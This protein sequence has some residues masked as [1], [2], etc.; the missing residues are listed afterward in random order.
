MANQERGVLTK[1]TN[2]DGQPHRAA[3]GLILLW[4]AAAGLSERW[5]WFARAASGMICVEL[6]VRLPGTDN[7]PSFTISR[8]VEKRTN[9]HKERRDRTQDMLVKTFRLF[10]LQ[11]V[12]RDQVV[13]FKGIPPMA[14]ESPE[15]FVQNESSLPVEERGCYSFMNEVFNRI[16]WLQLPPTVESELWELIVDD[17]IDAVE[18]LQRGT[19]Q[20]KMKY[21]IHDH[22]GSLSAVAGA[23]APAADDK[24]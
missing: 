2:G 13:Y 10:V 4:E 5:D 16:K 24:A 17:L 22:D 6:H 11:H 21:L 18:V 7:L 1:L 23:L 20:G 9:P 19:L 3:E 12:S 14:G 15:C 8:T